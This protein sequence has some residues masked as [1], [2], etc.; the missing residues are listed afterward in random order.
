MRLTNSQSYFLAFAK[1][2]TTHYRAKT[3]KHYAEII[4]SVFLSSFCS[5]CRVPILRRV[6]ML[7]ILCLQFPFLMERYVL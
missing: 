4:P 6:T 7:C 3:E 2:H 5:L 1:Q